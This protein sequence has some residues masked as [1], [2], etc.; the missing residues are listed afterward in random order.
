MRK[1][2]L[3]KS[4]LCCCCYVMA[5]ETKK[6]ELDSIF[7]EINLNEVTIAAT[8]F[9]EQ[10]KYLSQQALVVN[11][12]KIAFYNQQTSAELLTHTGS[13]LVQKS[14]LGGG[15]PL[16]RG[17]EANK[18]LIVVDGVR[19]NN[20]VFRAGHLQNVISMDNTIL[21]KMEVLF[22]P[23]SV[24]YG[25][26]ALGGVISFQTKKPRLADS[27]GNVNLGGNAFARY[28]SASNEKT[29]HADL[30]VGGKKIASLTSFTY[31]DFGDL[32]QGSRYFSR[33]PNWGK[34]SFYVER[35]IDKDSM[36]ANS[37]VNKQV[38]SGY[39]QYDLLQKILFTTGRIEQV[40]NFQYSTTSDIDR[41]DRLTET[42]GN[43]R[44]RSA[45][46]YYG[47]QRRMLA[48]WTVDLPTS[49]VYDK[50]RVTTAFQQVEES[51]HNRNYRSDNLD[52]RTEKLDIVSVN[53]DFARRLTKLEFGYGAEFTY[54]HVA[55]AAFRENISTGV[56]SALDTR[57]PDGGS[58]T[59]SYAAYL[60]ALYK[61]TGKVVFKA[62]LRF[63]HNRLRSQ[64]N[65]TT[66]FPFPYKDV[67]QSSNAVT[68][69]L[70][71]V[72]L[73]GAGWKIAALVS[74]GFRTPNVDDISK[75]FES[76]S[77]T[78]IVPNPTVKP[79]KT[80]NY[81][82]SISKTIQNKF[83]AGA[84]VW[85]TDYYNALSTDFSTFNGSPDIFY[86]GTLSRVVTVVNKNS[87]YLMGGSINVAAHFDQHF[88]FSSV[89]NYTY[90]RIKESPGNYPLDHVAPVFGKTS[91]L[92]KFGKFTSELFA[93]YN[94]A[95]TSA[96]YNL[97]GEDNHQYSA[98]VTNG[99]TPAWITYNARTVFEMN[100]YATVQFAIE[101]ITDK[102]Y[103]VFASGISAPGRNMVITLRCK[104]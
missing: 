73:P 93:L 45:Q 10:K 35:I 92:A 4:L 69:N 30:N 66:F 98:D 58:Q 67:R 80:I 65:D 21:D 70:G 46:W 96:D 79:E 100:T 85:Y 13:V 11:S 54:N 87:A 43:G 15:S 28:S 44:P 88:S 74:T 94:G 82:L 12:K 8:K 6:A 29:I 41:Y 99:Y 103:R 27:S 91:V 71:I 50:A 16:I 63:S 39:K 64:F 72:L 84:T 7:N 23:S 90:G 55:S 76:G 33:Y 18:V 36:I 48:A 101:N 22:G 3:L 9:A 68:G 1:L 78:L 32:T 42:N 97:R 40:L 5:Q 59:H 47:P 95:K 14:Q 60:T 89:I 31:S 17:F 75:V 37:K 77:G 2:F 52:H 34:R 19:M 24:M 62:G 20:A 104:M 25:S 81:E 51:R 86:N 83:Q 61:A 49:A 38:Q 57:Y 53:A 102:F 26:D 56:K